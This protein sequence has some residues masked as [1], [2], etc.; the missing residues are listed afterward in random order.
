MAAAS[1]PLLLLLLLVEED[2]AATTAEVCLRGTEM[3]VAE[4]LRLSVVVSSVEGGASSMLCGVVEVDAVA[5][6]LAVL[7]CAVCCCTGEV[8]ALAVAAVLSK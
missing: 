6:E 3:R 7:S 1:S 5:A 4:G 2:E 8:E